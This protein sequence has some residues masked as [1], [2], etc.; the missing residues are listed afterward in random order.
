MDYSSDNLWTNVI[1]HLGPEFTALFL[2]Y[3]TMLEVHLTVKNF[4][5]K[6]SVIV[7]VLKDQCFSFLFK[8]KILILLKVIS[9][10]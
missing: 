9:N 8:I 3:L 4:N 10:V 5:Y 7:L 1:D 2:R 6:I